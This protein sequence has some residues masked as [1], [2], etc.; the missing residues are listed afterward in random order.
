[1][2]HFHASRIRNGRQLITMVKERCSL[3]QPDT[4]GDVRAWIKGKECDL[5]QCQIS[6]QSCHKR[7]SAFDPLRTLALSSHV[8][9]ERQSARAGSVNLFRI[10]GM[11]GM[12]V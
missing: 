4:E 8:V 2:R 3:A 10:R 6:A 5:S 12:G 1:M 7:L 9:T 11:S